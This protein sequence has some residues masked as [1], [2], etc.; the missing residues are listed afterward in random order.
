MKI[1]PFAIVVLNLLFFLNTFSQEIM[2]ITQKDGTVIDIPLGEIRKLTFSE[3]IPTSHEQHKMFVKA[4][5]KIKSYPNPGKDI[6]TIEFNSVKKGDAHIQIYNLQG[7][8][9]ES[10]FM[11]GLSEGIHKYNFDLQAFLPGTYLCKV[12]V[13]GEI[14]IEKIIVKN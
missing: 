4:L 1:K 5:M 2:R 9:L 11:I 10:Q 6:I 13:N 12:F 8:L 7:R 3:G 14:L